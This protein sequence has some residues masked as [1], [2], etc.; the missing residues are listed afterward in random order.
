MAGRGRAG[1][2]ITAGMAMETMTTTIT[3]MITDH[4][5][6]TTAVT[7]PRP[8]TIMIT[9]HRATVTTTATTTTTTSTT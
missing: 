5:I 2:T 8:V 6:P 4:T 9:D 3:T 7:P 1:H